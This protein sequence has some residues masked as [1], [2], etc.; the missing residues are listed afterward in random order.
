MLRGSGDSVV[1]A[2][3]LFKSAGK[4]YEKTFFY[5]NLLFAGFG[6]KSGSSRN[7]V[8]IEWLQNLQPMKRIKT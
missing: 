4:R 1:L 2:A 3:F 8:P 7:L 6:V 5:I